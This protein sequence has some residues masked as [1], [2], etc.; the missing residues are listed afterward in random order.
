M[1]KQQSTAMRNQTQQAVLLEIDDDAVGLLLAERSG[2]VYDAS[3]SRLQSWHGHK[4][5]SVAEA[6]TIL[7]AALKRANDR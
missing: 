6:Q 1:T 2:F 4:F 7:A 5:S 3:D